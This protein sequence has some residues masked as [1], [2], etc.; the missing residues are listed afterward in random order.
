MKPRRVV[1]SI[2]ATTAEPLQGLKEAI[3]RSLVQAN[4]IRD[5]PTRPRSKRKAKP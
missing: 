1:I 3:R 4:V 5:K 2:E